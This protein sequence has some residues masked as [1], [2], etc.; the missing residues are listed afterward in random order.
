MNTRNDDGDHQARTTTDHDEIRA[1]VEARGGKPATV[2][3]T[4]EDGEAG[5]LR[6]CFRNDDDALEVIDWEA[7]FEKFDEENL[8]FLFQ[9][10][11]EGGDTSRFFKFVQREG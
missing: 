3:D 7:F 11:T 8:A 6:I 9:E 4:A 5:V 10:R 1:W 2:R